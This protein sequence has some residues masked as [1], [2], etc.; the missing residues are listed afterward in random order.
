L[1]VDKIGYELGKWHRVTIGQENGIPESSAVS[2]VRKWLD[3]L[4]SSLPVWEKSP[5]NK[6]V[7]RQEFELLL[8][9]LA[10]SPLRF[11]HNDVLPFNILLNPEGETKFIDYE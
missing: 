9:R 8:P 11:C 6:L 1:H 2:L 5:Y 7:L 10:A 3:L 4:P